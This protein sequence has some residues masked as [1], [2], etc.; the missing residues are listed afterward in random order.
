MMY[1]IGDAVGF[2]FQYQISER[3]RFGYSYDLPLT[4]M[5]RNSAG[6]HEICVTYDFLFKDKKIVTPRNF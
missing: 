1:R 6:S 2:I 3:L 5:M 4:E